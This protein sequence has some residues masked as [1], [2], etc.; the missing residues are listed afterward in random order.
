MKYPQELIPRAQ[1]EMEKFQRCAADTCKALIAEVVRLQGLLKM[2]ALDH[3][4]ECP[5]CFLRYT[6]AQCESED[7]PSCGNNGEDV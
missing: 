4:H 6:P 3:S 2:N 7:C 1:F 5:A